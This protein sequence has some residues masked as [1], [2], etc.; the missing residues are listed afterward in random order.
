MTEYQAKVR[1]VGKQGAYRA[2]VV[3]VPETPIVAE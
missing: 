1:V 3:P 2:S